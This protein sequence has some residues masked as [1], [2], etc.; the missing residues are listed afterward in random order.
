[1]SFI[2]GICFNHCIYLLDAAL[3]PDHIVN[4]KEDV[5]DAELKIHYIEKQCLLDILE[6]KNINK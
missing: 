1:M 3:K 5:Y 4:F 2:E 6:Y